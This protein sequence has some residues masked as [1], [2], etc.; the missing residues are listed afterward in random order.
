MCVLTV[1]ICLCL[2]SVFT[3]VFIDEKTFHYIHFVCTQHSQG[4]A[5]FL[6]QLIHYFY[7]A[8]EVVGL[9]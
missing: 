1:V 4:D 3:I 5:A 8:R 6:A 2:Q 9:K 7:T